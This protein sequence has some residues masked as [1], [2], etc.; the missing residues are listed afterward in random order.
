MEAG[1]LARAAGQD[2]DSEVALV[3]GQLPPVRE[4]SHPSGPLTGPHGGV[5]AVPA[6]IA[7]GYDVHKISILNVDKKMY[8]EEPEDVGGSGSVS[9]SFKTS[10]TNSPTQSLP[11]PLAILPTPLESLPVTHNEEMAVEP[12]D[13]KEIHCHSPSS[14][15]GL[16]VAS[17]EAPSRCSESYEEAVEA[18]AEPSAVTGSDHA[19]AHEAEKVEVEQYSSGQNTVNERVKR[20]FDDF[21]TVH[22]NDVSCS[23][24]VPMEKKPVSELDDV[25]TEFSTPHTADSSQFIS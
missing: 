20:K 23:R 15:S 19:A 4:F 12:E 17:A 2:K 6:A 3:E 25:G 7:T 1:E 10:R 16:A 11:E 18:T 9:V 5:E 21:D 8:E 13:R 24:N 14:I 22:S